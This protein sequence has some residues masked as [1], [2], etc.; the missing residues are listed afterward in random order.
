MPKIFDFDLTVTSRHTFKDYQLMTPKHTNEQMKQSITQY[1]NGENYGRM[2]LKEDIEKHLQHNSE[3]FSAIATFH[4]NPN[5]VAGCV[6]LVLDKELTFKEQ[7]IRK[8]EGGYD[9]AVN[10]YSVNEEKNPFYI[11]YIP[12]INDFNNARKSLGNKNQQINHILDL[13][14]ENRLI[15]AET[16]IDFYDD[17]QVNVQSVQPLKVINSYKVCPITEKF[18]FTLTIS[19]SNESLMDKPEAAS[20]SSSVASSTESVPRELIQEVFADKDHSIGDEEAEDLIKEFSK[21]ARFFQNAQPQRE[22]TKEY[23]ETTDSVLKKS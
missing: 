16:K 5:F 9:I 13:W 11:S 3:N 1:T 21:T 19:S 14:M 18:T 10:V 8:T 2:F 20:S 22:E 6:A 15:D 12:Y 7:L 23:A 4:N 17:T